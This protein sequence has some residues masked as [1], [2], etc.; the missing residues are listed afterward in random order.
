M[1]GFDAAIA[2]HRCAIELEEVSVKEGARRMHSDF[3]T[4]VEGR[5]DKL[6]KANFIREVQYPSW[7]QTECHLK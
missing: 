3:T 5:V 4:K 7:M 2:M 6:I 1:L